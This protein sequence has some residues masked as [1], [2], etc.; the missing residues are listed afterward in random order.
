[1]ATR[2]RFEAFE[3][4]SPKG[5]RKAKPD[6]KRAIGYIRVSTDEQQL[7]P[8]A[9][10]AAIRAYATRAGLE[11]VEIVRDLGVSGGA[12]LDERPG[13]VEALDALDRHQAATLVVSKRDRLARDSTRGAFVERLVESAGA[14]VVSADGVAGGSSP[15]D[16][17]L[18]GIMDAFAE[19][20][21]A[22]IRLRTRAALAAKRRKGERLGQIPYGFR[23][24]E[25]GKLV[26][27]AAE[28]RVVMFIL[29]ERDGGA[30][31]Q[32][33]TDALQTTYKPRGKSGT[34]H[35][36]SVHRIYTA[37]DNARKAGK[38]AA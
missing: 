31:W 20:E 27:D 38:P 37:A 16:K 2:E 11:V 29:G 23:A 33:I 4:T 28:Q 36:T 24:G 25:D 13:L 12:P 26:P 21:R 3:A 8:E 5:K 17:L 18:R 30:T 6:P 9:Q 35:M 34:W 32:E 1:M 10:E 19:Y 7:G 22:A 15:E 14:R